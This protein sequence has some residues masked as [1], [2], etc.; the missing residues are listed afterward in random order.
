MRPASSAFAQNSGEGAVRGWGLT[1]ACVRIRDGFEGV[2]VEKGSATVTVWPLGVV[3]A[4]FA[5]APAD[6]TAGQVHIHV[7]VT[8]VRVAIT[9]ASWE[10]RG[11][12]EITPAHLP[13]TNPPIFSLFFSYSAFFALIQHEYKQLKQVLSKG[14]F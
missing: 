3:P 11:V 6:A 9:A 4:V 5:H 2:P 8:A 10:R 7:E 1:K 13:C 14:S 12:L